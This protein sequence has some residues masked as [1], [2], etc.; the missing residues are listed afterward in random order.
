MPPRPDG[1]ATRGSQHWLQ[2]LV[3]HRPELLDGPLAGAIQLP[4]SDLI[5]WISPLAA[6]GYRE[7]RDHEFLTRLGAELPARSLESFWPARGPVWD[8]LACSTPR[9]LILVEA[10]AHVA[11]IA[12]PASKASPDSMKRIRASLEETQTHLGIDPEKYDWAGVFYQYVNRLA[13]LYLLRVLNDRP[14]WL[15]LLYFLNDPD[16]KGPTTQ[17]EWEAALA[18]LHAALGLPKQHKM[19]RWVVNLFV[20]VSMVQG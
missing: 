17:A 18:V 2:V 4:E 19:A 12:S 9:D 20:D 6:D 15:V 10:K 16:M 1:P 11:E 13:H 8:G 14:A 5:S 7:Y 3:N